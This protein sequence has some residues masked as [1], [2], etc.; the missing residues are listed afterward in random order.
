MNGQI[1]RSIVNA[2]SERAPVGTEGQR[3]GHKEGQRRPPGE[4]Y[5]RLPYKDYKGGYEALLKSS[6]YVIIL[7]C[8]PS[9]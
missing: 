6:G 2:H 9:T 3:T 7:S 8:K 4:G 5:K 1:N